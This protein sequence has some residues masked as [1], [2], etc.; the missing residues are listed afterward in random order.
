MLNICDSKLN[1]YNE[2]ENI[3]NKNV[4]KLCNMYAYTIMWPSYLPVSPQ[5][6]GLMGEK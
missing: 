6:K 3:I 1:T 4:L 2:I 5:P